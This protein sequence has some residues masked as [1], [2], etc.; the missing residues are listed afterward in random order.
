VGY[1]TGSSANQTLS[2]VWNGTSWSVVLPS[3]QGTNQANY[4]EGVACVSTT[5]CWAAGYYQTAAPWDQTL[6]EQ[7]N[8]TSWS[9]VSSPN[10]GST[11]HNLFTGVTCTSASACW[12][13][14]YY[15]P[16]GGNAQTEV[17]KYNGTSWSIYTSGNPSTGG[18]ELYALTCQSSTNC[19]SV[20]TQFNGTWW[21]TLTEQY[22]GGASYSAV[23]SPNTS[24]TYTNELF[25]VSCTSST[26]CWNGG[27]NNNNV[28]ANQNLVEHWDGTSWT[29]PSGGALPLGGAPNEFSTTSMDGPFGGG[30][31]SNVPGATLALSGSEVSAAGMTL[32]ENA[33]GTQVTITDQTGTPLVFNLVGSTWTPPTYIGPSAF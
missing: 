31:H 13:S 7:Y 12:A 5:N 15:I 33:A 3:N 1:Y 4:L 26:N 2:E 28:A 32:V 19:W 21:Q 17:Q 8:G 16:T 6:V 25:G 27:Q 29:I 18:D 24:T 10:N 22:T 20:G 11:Q 14:G 30:W 9:I 23:S